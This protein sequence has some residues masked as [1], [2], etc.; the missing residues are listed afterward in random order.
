MQRPFAFPGARPRYA[1]DRVV[2]IEHYRIEVRL[3]MQERRIEAR[4]AITVAAKLEEVGRLELDAVELDVRAV[5][6]EG[7]PLPFRTDGERLAVTFPRKLRAGER[8]TL[9]VDYAAH[10]RR[11]LYFLGPDEGYPARRP[12]V[13]SQ[14]QDEDSRHWFPC[15]D[16][17][18]AKSTTEVLATVPESLFALSN[19]TLVDTQHDPARRERTFHWRLDVPHSCYLVTL[20]AAELAEVKDEWEGVA[21]RYYVEPGREADARRSLGKTPQMLECFSRRFGVRYPYPSYA[22]VC[23][24]DFI[25]GG[26]ENTTATTLT[27][28][29]LLDDRAAIDSDQEAL[30]AHELA[31]QWFGDLVTCRDWGQG[32][33][34][35]GFATYSEYVW[36]EW[37]EGRD[38]AHLELLD[39]RH[40][41][42]EEDQKRYRRPVAT[43]VYDE[44]TDVFDRH[45]YEKGGLV[46]H[47]LRGVLGDVA[48]ERTLAHYLEK[49]RGGLVE[50]R[51]LARA[52]ESATG[53]AVDW[54]FEQ[55]IE[56]AGHPELEVA[57]GWDDERKL[58]RFS[59][60]QTQKVDHETPLFRLP[61]AVRFRVAGADVTLPLEVRDAAEV[62]F[63]PLAEAPTQ[64]IFDAG[65]STL[66]SLEIEKPVPLWLAELAQASDAADRIAAAEALEK[67]TSDEVVAALGRALGGDGFWGVRA[68]AAA[69]LGHIRSA[70]ARAVLVAALADAGSDPRVRRAVAKA[71][72]EFRHDEVAAA[73]LEVVVRA[74]D[75]SQW[76]EGEACL[77]LG[78]TRSPRAHAALRE[79]LVRPSYVDFIRASSY[80]GLA[81]ARD[82]SAVPLLLE[83]TTYGMK[84]QGRRAAAAALAT[85]AQ[86]RTDADARAARERLEELLEDRDFRVTQSALEAV[87]T[88]GDARSLPALRRA[89]DTHLDGR[90]RRRARELVRD[91]E[92]GR[93]R[94]EATKLLRDEVDRLRQEVIALRERLGKLEAGPAPGSAATRPGKPAALP[95]SAARAAAPAAKPSRAT[96]AAPGAKPSRA[97]A[98]APAANSSRAAKPTPAARAK[99][100]KL[101][102][103]RS[104]GR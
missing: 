37:S 44:P 84:S 64:A 58:A 83:G 28:Q 85:L 4:C 1:P 71:L 2:D 25:F 23:V 11:G 52:V 32:W 70:A 35:E 22:Q 45:L 91:L 74:G 54:F 56:K 48:F 51:D 96:A 66:A 40:Q 19:G 16:A 80:R 67:H 77:A 61:L 30:V 49:H 73:A 88:L 59:V 95:A 62:F 68:A 63:F 99:R 69:T 78:R 15:F 17:P 100:A 41:Y 102:K 50:T 10:P 5:T 97:A 39:W 89:I 65:R 14:G 6:L 79:S 72:G 29:C 31:H 27:D 13:W 38:A 101:G 87:A 47:M 94:D 76:V 57:Y 92:E 86:G 9:V 55:W 53:R 104:R 26:M 98:T 7:A 90:I 42:F 33:L 21:V 18:N 8:H 3:L 43:N 46:L 34:N 75:R 60:K 82:E 81:E 36:R 12:Q 103:P 24:A 20:A 93:T